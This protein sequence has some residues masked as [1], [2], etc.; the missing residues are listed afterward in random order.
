MS[1]R[2]LI[3]RLRVSTFI[4]L[5]DEERAREQEVVFSVEIEPAPG[6]I[7]AAAAGDDIENTVDYSGAAQMIRA[8]AASRPR[9]LLET[10]AEETATALFALPGIVGLTLQIDKFVLPGAD[11]TSVRIV[12]RKE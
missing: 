9:R 12:R 1:D 3:S 10:L 11:S 7:A 6:A 8:V 2:I 4:G 5:Y